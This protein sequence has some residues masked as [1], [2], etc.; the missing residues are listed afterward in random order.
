MSSNTIQRILSAIVMVC[1]ASLCVYFGKVSTTALIFI[2]GLIVNYEIVINL[3]E[4]KRSSLSHI[5]TQ[6]FYIV[7]FYFCLESK[8][9]SY[10]AMILSSLWSCL[11]LVY[12]FAMPMQNNMMSFIKKKAPLFTL[13]FTLLPMIS[14][15][16][17]LRFEH[18]TWV[19]S[20]LLIVNFG[21]DTGAWFFGKTFG[22]R[23]LWPKISPN[24]TIEGF[25]GGMATSGVLGHLFWVNFFDNSVTWIFIPM[26]ILGCLSQL[27]DL[28]QSKLKRQFEIKDSSHLIP[29][30]GG[31]YDR[32]DSL[33]FVLPFFGLVMSYY[34]N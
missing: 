18:W 16:Y 10:K 30:H 33:V 14:L 17:L 20:L 7:G 34:L 22:K 6:F 24:K 19:L 21:M 1:I 31:M 9:Y 11:Q 29:G 12:L 25:I 15:C 5:T 23:K 8:S 4:K 13:F 26:A 2:V 32:V 28:T 27:G 3:F